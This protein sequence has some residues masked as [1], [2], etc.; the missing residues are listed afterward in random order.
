MNAHTDSQDLDPLLTSVQPR[1]SPHHW[2]P[3][4]IPNNALQH[5]T[6]NG[7]NASHVPHFCLCPI[8]AWRK[9]PLGGQREH[10]Q[11]S[12]VVEPCTSRPKKPPT[13]PA[14]R[15]ALS[16][17]ATPVLTKENRRS[18]N[19]FF[20]FLDLQTLN[21]VPSFLHWP[22]DVKLAHQSRT[23]VL[24]TCLIVGFGS[25]QIWMTTSWSS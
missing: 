2:P 1:T 22:W 16:Q 20:A 19:T 3:I 10:C 21:P 23:V 15:A 4:F 12:L 11:P 14:A 9:V 17:L 6:R 8:P 5:I 13:S 25:F 18:I 24:D 7:S